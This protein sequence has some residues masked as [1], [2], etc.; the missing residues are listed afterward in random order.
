[1]EI[2]TGDGREIVTISDTLHLVSHEDLFIVDPDPKNTKKTPLSER[3]FRKTGGGRSGLHQSLI[4]DI[5]TAMSILG[6]DVTLA[7]SWLPPNDS[8]AVFV[9]PDSMIIPSGANDEFYK[10]KN[11]ELTIKDVDYGDEGI[12]ECHGS[13]SKKASKK[14][15]KVLIL[16]CRFTG[17]P[18]AGC[19]CIRARA[20]G[21]MTSYCDCRSKKE[22]VE[23]L[24]ATYPWMPGNVEIV[25]VDIL[26]L[27]YLGLVFFLVVIPFHQKKM[28]RLL[29][30][31]PAEPGQTG[32]ESQSE[33]PSIAVP[34][35]DSGMPS[36]AVLDNDSVMPSSKLESDDN[37]ATPS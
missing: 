17:C 27:S 3:P 19:A 31:E 5:E 14:K 20:S 21:L 35:S 34:D 36:I 8:I 10:L 2:R 26:L 33:T 6:T 32:D 18:N 12:Y 4:P 24:V 22:V 25:V 13:P 23:E 11:L 28:A 15:F 16:D 7:C 1:V 9:N 37:S 29:G 30:N